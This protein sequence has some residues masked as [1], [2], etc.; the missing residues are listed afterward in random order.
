MLKHSDIKPHFFDIIIFIVVF[1][2]SSNDTSPNENGA[3]AA[4]LTSGLSCV[5]GVLGAARG[6]GADCPAIPRRRASR[7][8]RAA[9]S[10]AT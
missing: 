10:T 3:I 2:D 6:D 9:T 8:R 7:A 4:T 5:M 1:Y